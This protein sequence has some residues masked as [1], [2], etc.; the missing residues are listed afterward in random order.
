MSYLKDENAKEPMISKGDLITLIVM[1]VIGGGF[2]YYYNTS[3]TETQ[4]AFAE[5]DALYKQKNYT[6]ALKAYEKLPELSWRSDSLEK[7]MYERTS[8]LADRKE[9]E[10]ILFEYLDSLSQSPDS[11][12]LKTRLAEFKHLDFLSSE[13]KAKV[14]QWQK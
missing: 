10:E 12:Q 7:I 1:I 13:Q 9:Q 3:K 5:A 2:W 6:E 4:K 8:E 11:S 14:L